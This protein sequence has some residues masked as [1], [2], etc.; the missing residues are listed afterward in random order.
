[1]VDIL[2]PESKTAYLEGLGMYRLDYDRYSEEGFG[3]P[4]IFGE[5]SLERAWDFS[6]K[7]LEGLKNG[8]T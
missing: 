5:N 1:M 2:L 4:I 7:Y 3:Y 6:N 8:N